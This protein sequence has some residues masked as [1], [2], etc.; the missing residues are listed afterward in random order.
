[1]L[2]RY[3]ETEDKFEV[4]FKAIEQQHKFNFPYQVFQIKSKLRSV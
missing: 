2:L 1:M 3:N 4:F